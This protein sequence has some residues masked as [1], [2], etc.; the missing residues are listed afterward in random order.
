LKIAKNRSFFGH[1]DP[2]GDFDLIFGA[3]RF[4]LKVVE[5]P[6]RYRERKYGATNISRWKH[7]A[8]LLKMLVL[9]AGKF[10]FL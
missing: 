5:L 7:G 8:L 4:N 9:A 3:V 2:F 1:I 10:K 6:I